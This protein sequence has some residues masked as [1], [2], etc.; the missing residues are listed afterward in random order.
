IERP[1]G[2]RALAATPP[3]EP[4]IPLARGHGSGRT[5]FPHAALG[6]AVFGLDQQRVGG[7]AEAA[8]V[9]DVI[10]DHAARHAPQAHV[11][12]DAVAGV[13]GAV[14]RLLDRAVVMVRRGARTLSIDDDERLR[15]HDLPLLRELPRN[16]NRVPVP[17][18]GQRTLSLR[19][20]RAISASA[21]DAGHACRQVVAR[22]APGTARAQW[23]AVARGTKLTLCATTVSRIFATCGRSA[24]ITCISQRLQSNLSVSVSSP[25]TSCIGSGRMPFTSL[26]HR[27]KL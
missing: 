9:R 21:C 27:L 1:A 12:A 16:G 24:P 17:V 25:L 5:D 22:P 7:A 6:D 19:Q 4:V 18:D 15:V 26:G 2:R 8:K 14:N 20:A 10:A 3:V 13:D 11:A 23:L